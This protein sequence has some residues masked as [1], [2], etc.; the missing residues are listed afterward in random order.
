MISLVP[1]TGIASIDA[2][3]DYVGP[4]TQTCLDNA[5]LLEAIA[6]VD[7]YDDRQIA[8]TPFRKDVP[9]Y[10]EILESTKDQGVKGMKIGILKEGLTS[11]ALDPEVD[12]KFQAAAS[13]FQKLGATVEE[14]SIPMHDQSRAIYTVMSKLGNHMGML[15]RAT[16]RR[17][18]MLTDM[19]EKK[20][21]PYTQESLDK[22]SSVRTTSGLLC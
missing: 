18:V 16:G 10:A 1:Y 13:V 14:I 11:S 8:G 9:H 5:L 4:I 6:G 15:G 21:F 20:K 7:G 19:F 3:V 2:S 17:Q 12:K 22:V